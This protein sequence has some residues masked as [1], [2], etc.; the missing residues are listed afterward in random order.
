MIAG[1][2]CQVFSLLVFISLCVDF[3][4]RVKKNGADP[5]E[6]LRRCRCEV[7]RFYSFLVGKYQ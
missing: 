5:G 2:S 1:L 6:G 7:M 3:A 4:V